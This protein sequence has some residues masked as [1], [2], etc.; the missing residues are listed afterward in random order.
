M[1]NKKGKAIQKFT[2][3][4]IDDF[5]RRANAGESINKMASEEGFG[6]STFNYWTRKRG[7]RKSNEPA[8]RAQSSKASASKTS[9]S[10]NGAGDKMLETLR[11]RARSLEESNEALS[12]TNTSL[13]ERLSAAEDKN[14]RL[15]DKVLDLLLAE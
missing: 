15:S 7:V 5:I 12:R 8:R 1:A 6:R 2:D 3:E 11:A 4:Q 10:K 13:R 14:K 9:A